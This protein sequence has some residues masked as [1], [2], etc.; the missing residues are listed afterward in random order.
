MRIRGQLLAAALLAGAAG[1]ASAEILTL[2]YSSGFHN[3]AW[4]TGG[5]NGSSLNVV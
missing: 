5:S 2:N 4:L 1:T 3:R